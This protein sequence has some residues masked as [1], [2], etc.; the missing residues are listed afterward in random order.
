MVPRVAVADCTTEQLA[1][2]IGLPARAVRHA[3]AELQRADPQLVC[4]QVDEQLGLRS[5]TTTQ[6]AADAMQ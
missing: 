5:W 4:E 6:A 3:L 1:Q 2:R